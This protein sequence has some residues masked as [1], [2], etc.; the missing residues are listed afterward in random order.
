MWPCKY[1][2]DASANCRYGDLKELYGKADQVCLKANHRELGFSHLYSKRGFAGRL[3]SGV[4]AVFYPIVPV[5][6]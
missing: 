5:R 1:D 3:S 2:Q 4:Q 6:L